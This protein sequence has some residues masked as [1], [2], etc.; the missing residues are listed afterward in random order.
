[1]DDEE[2][3]VEEVDVDVDADRRELPDDVGP[4]ARGC[5]VVIGD[6]A[7]LDEEPRLEEGNQLARLRA[8]VRGILNADEPSLDDVA[9]DGMGKS[10]TRRYQVGGWMDGEAVD[11]AEVGS[12]DARVVAIRVRTPGRPSSSC[13]KGTRLTAWTLMDGWLWTTFCSNLLLAER[14]WL[15]RKRRRSVYVW[16]MVSQVQRGLSVDAYEG[17]IGPGLLMSIERQRRVD[18]RDLRGKVERRANVVVE[19]KKEQAVRKWKG[20]E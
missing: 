3:D 11:A 17:G 7:G 10:V 13:A 20:C 16:W 12:K 6:W 2:V 5:I 9:V 15:D 19:N 18:R 4:S 1:V 14:G 8:L